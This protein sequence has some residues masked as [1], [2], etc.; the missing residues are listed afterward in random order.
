MLS[1]VIR[2]LENCDFVGN[3]AHGSGGAISSYGFRSRMHEI[4]DCTFEANEAH[5]G[6][7][8]YVTLSNFTGVD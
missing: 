7:A 4:K 5:D 1:L 6:G 2:L 8:I 3:T